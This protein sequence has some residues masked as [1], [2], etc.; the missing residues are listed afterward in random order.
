MAT[1]MI[2]E[3]EKKIDSAIE[4][5]ELMR[6]QVEELEERNTILHTENAELKAKQ[7]SWESNLSN[8][9]QKLDNVA[10]TREKTELL[11]VE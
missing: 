2:E 8:M 7:V 6:L 5:I 1:E 4:T 3:L 9:L 11:A 10:S